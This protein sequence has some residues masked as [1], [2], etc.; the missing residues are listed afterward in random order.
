[1]GRHLDWEGTY[2]AR[3]LGGLPAR[4]GRTTLRGAVVRS[5]SLDKLTPRGWSALQEHGVRTIVDLRSVAEWEQR[6]YEP[7]PGVERVHVPLEEG[8]EDDPEFRHWTA[9]GM[10]ATPLYY[11]RFLARWPERCAAAV[12]AVAHAPDGGVLVHCHMGRDRAGIVAL[13][14]LTLAGAGAEDI[15]ADHTAS[16]RRLRQ[17]G[18]PL[19]Y[20]DDSIWVEALLEGD[21][22][23]AEEVVAGLARSLDADAY[24]R[25][26]GLSAGEVASVR[27]RLL[28]PGS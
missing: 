12:A 14:L 3:D 9:T 7:P 28:V 5:E 4:D 6:S 2:N 13:L 15:A 11:Q 18:V 25:Q 24:L 16:Q 17:V 22:T 8:L 20:N 19:G 23:T 26:A 21:N 10:L 1:M 27:D